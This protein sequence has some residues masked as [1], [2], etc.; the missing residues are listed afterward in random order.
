MQMSK[1]TRITEYAENVGNDNLTPERVSLAKRHVS[2][3]FHSARWQIDDAF[4]RIV[5]GDLMLSLAI[6]LIDPHAEWLGWLDA[7]QRCPKP[8]SKPDLISTFLE[9]R[10]SNHTF[11]TCVSSEM[12]QPQ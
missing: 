8:R 12:H 5:A 7:E 6:P 9:T 10:N 11:D 4:G 2:H 1:Q 3:R